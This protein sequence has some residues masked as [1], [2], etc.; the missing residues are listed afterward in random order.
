LKGFKVGASTCQSRIIGN[1]QTTNCVDALHL[2]WYELL[3]FRVVPPLF[4]KCFKVGLNM[5]DMIME[6]QQTS[7]Q[8][9]HYIWFESMNFALVLFRLV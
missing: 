4:E 8:L 7:Q 5:Q 9:M 6:N 3:L 2:V 1:Q